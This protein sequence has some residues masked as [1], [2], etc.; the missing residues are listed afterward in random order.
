[1]SYAFDLVHLPPGVDREEA[2]EHMQQQKANSF[3]HL[4]RSQRLG[5]IDPAKEEVKRRLAAALQQRHRSLKTFEFDYSRI[6]QSEGISESEARRLYRHLEL[7]DPQLSIRILLFDDEAGT[8][9]AF[10]GDAGGCANALR[11]LWD[12][13]EIMESA[14]GYSTHDP[15]LGKFLDLK[16]DFGLVLKSVCGVEENRGSAE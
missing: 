2:Y 6:A 9:F 10:S 13:L 15:Q 12:C 5:P 3:E 1:M 8:E 16:S 4:S 14:G 7:N 11:E